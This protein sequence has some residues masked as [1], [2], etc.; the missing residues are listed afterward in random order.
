[1]HKV[2]IEQSKVGQKKRVS[3][4]G[5]SY[6]SLSEMYSKLGID[7]S[8]VANYKRTGMSQEEAISF[9]IDQAAKHSENAK[10]HWDAIEESQKRREEK[11]KAS[12]FHFNSK[13]YPTFRRAVEDLSWENDIFLNAQSIKAS[14]K[15]NRRTLE[16]QLRLTLDKHLRRKRRDDA[17]SKKE[18]GIFSHKMMGEIYHEIV[19]ILAN[20]GCDGFEDENAVFVLTEFAGTSIEGAKDLL[21]DMKENGKHYSR[22][23]YENRDEIRRRNKEEA[24]RHIYG[25]WDWDSEPNYMYYI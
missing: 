21:D 16:E 7:D 24:Y 22:F 10:K 15:K 19:D 14:A 11:R 13:T 23:D 2:K 3:V 25:R 17:D 18:Y 12:V 4:D 1:M 9:A 8:T 6:A 5:I 20:H